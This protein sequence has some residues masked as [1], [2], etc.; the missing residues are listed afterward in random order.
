MKVTFSSQ[1]YCLYTKSHQIVSFIVEGS[2]DNGL[3]K[4]TIYSNIPNHT[5][6]MTFSEQKAF[7]GLEKERRSFNYDLTKVSFFD[8]RLPL[9]VGNYKLGVKI[10][11]G[12]EEFFTFSMSWIPSET[13]QK[14]WCFGAHFNASDLVSSSIQP[15]KIT[16][17]KII[18]ISG[19][20]EK[21]IHQLNWD[22]GA[23]T[24]SWSNG[25]A[26]LIDNDYSRFILPDE[27]LQVGIAGGDYM[28]IE[29]GNLDDLPSEDVTENLITDSSKLE[30][31]AIRTIISRAASYL[32]NYVGYYAEPKYLSTEKKDKGA[33]YVDP[34]ALIYRPRN[35]T[36]AL[37]FKLPVAQLQGVID[38]W[39][40]YAGSKVAILDSLEIDFNSFGVISIQSPF[41]TFFN[42]V[43]GSNMMGA[44]DRTIYSN[45]V[46]VDY[47]STI[48]NFW[49]YKIIAGVTDNEV[50]QSCLDAISMLAS[51][52]VLS[53]A[54]GASLPGVTS[55]SFE[56]DG[57]KGAQ[58]YNTKPT[59]G[60]Y[61][62]QIETYKDILG[63]IKEDKGAHRGMLHRLRGWGRGSQFLNV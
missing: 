51:I 6:V 14:V 18:E 31:E 26:I 22:S 38:I 53:I 21:A 44:W 11:T 45:A 46:N 17:V 28:V 41:P 60:R 47:Q 49:N 50:Q 39:G 5:Y 24:L 2:N 1:E 58:S 40:E 19:N 59:E 23:K 10:G 37:K 61:A 42:S 34:I 52:Q 20:T 54:A 13:L 32:T 4:A 8:G 29:T 63:L 43:I 62:T 16:G 3:I 12:V 9:A 56:K 36:N 35:S 57:Y 48:D 27:M 7:T 55:D 33:I 15:Q 30:Q 25:D